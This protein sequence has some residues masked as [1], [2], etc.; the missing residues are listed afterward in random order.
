MNFEPVDPARALM[1]ILK[2]DLENLRKEWIIDISDYI[3]YNECGLAYDILISLIKEESYKPSDEAL[4]LIKL[5]GTM[6]GVAYPRL[7]SDYE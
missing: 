3:F 7:S 6:L 2:L 5:T 1:R 4:R